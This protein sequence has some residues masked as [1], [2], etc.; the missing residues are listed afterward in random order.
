MWMYIE[1]F[2]DI[3]YKIYIENARVGLSRRRGDLKSKW[4]VLGLA[5]PSALL[6]PL[7]RRYTISDSL[8]VCKL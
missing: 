5:D 7:D 2:I 4:L 6:L 1:I 3:Y 8:A